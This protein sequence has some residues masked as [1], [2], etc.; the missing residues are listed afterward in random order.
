MIAAGDLTAYI[1]ASWRPHTEHHR[2]IEAVHRLSDLGAVVTHVAHG[3][4]QEGFDAEW[5]QIDILTVEGDRI[6]RIEIFDEAD[7]D[8]ALTRFD[9]LSPPAPRLENAASQAYERFWTYFAARD[10]A[11]LAELLADDI[12]T[13]DRRRVVNAGA[14]HGRDAE[15]ADMRVLADLGMTNV[16]VDRHRRPAAS[17]SPSL[18]SDVRQLGR[19]KPRYSAS[20]RSTPTTGSWRIVAFDLD[21]ID[22]AFEELDARYLAGE[23]AAHAHTWSVIA[24]STPRSI[25]TNSP[26][27]HPTGSTSTTDEAHGRAR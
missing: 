13:D 6:N 15:I 10:W 16:T 26:R 12:F 7:L 19:F 2:Y 20:S 17:A 3:T 21:D 25:G 14:R 22:A 5:R 18:V 23:A 9:E 1:R 24:E 4:S 11:A 8:A 27:R